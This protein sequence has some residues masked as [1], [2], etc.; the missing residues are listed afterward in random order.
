MLTNSSIDVGREWVPVYEEASF[1][2]KLKMRFKNIEDTLAF[3]RDV[4]IVWGLVFES[5]PPQRISQ[6]RFRRSLLVQN[7]GIGSLVKLYPK[8]QLP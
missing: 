3:R 1:I 6:G 8:V 2:P 5:L 4:P 7:K